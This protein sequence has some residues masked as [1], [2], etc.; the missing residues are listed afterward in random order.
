VEEVTKEELVQE[1]QKEGAAVE[2]AQA[3]EGA[4]KRKS[5]DSD[6]EKPQD[7]PEDNTKRAR[8]AADAIA[9][10][11]AA[12][13]LAVA[14]SKGQAQAQGVIS[15]SLSVEGKYVGAIIGQG[16]RNIK[17]TRTTSGASVN[18]A[19]AE[20]GATEREVTFTG[21]QEQVTL[22]K[23]LVEAQVAAEGDATGT[24]GAG[25]G[26]GMAAGGGGDQLLPGETTATMSVPSSSVGG[27]IGRGGSVIKHIRA[28]SGCRIRVQDSSELP[29]GAPDRTVTITGQPYSVEYAQSLIRQVLEQ[30]AMGLAMGVGNPTTGMAPQAYGQPQ[31]GGY[32][33]MQGYGAQDPMGQQTVQVS[34]PDASVGGIIGRGGESINGIRRATGAR[35]EI[36]SES[37]GGNRVVT[38]SGSPQAIQMAQ[39]QMS[40]KMME[41]AP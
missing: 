4:G 8:L 36:A 25:G 10:A 22:A 29:H 24:G 18:I 9:N 11:A 19:N 1:E 7:D 32:G 17:G 23:Q 28:S 14:A 3:G 12:A 33:Q 16:G 40:V 21:T 13:S 26:F 2:E 15:E 37:M 34:V 31:M 39:Y 38:I 5:E 20:P 41:Q 35:I 30:P 27:I 6:M